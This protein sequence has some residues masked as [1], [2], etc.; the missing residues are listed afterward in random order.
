VRLHTLR[1]VA[2]AWDLYEDMKDPERWLVRQL[3]RG[4]FHGTKIGRHWRMSDRDIEA[5][6]EVLS[7]GPSNVIEHPTLGLTP[8]SLRRRA[9]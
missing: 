3:R 2:E 8:A 1:E 9:S 4:R 6:L 5:A 7:S